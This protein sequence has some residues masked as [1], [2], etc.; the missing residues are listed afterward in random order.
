MRPA[1]AP[2]NLY[3]TEKMATQDV[4]PSLLIVVS[5]RIT[6]G[7][8]YVDVARCFHDQGVADAIID[9]EDHDR[10]CFLVQPPA[11]FAPRDF[12]EGSSLVV[13]LDF[14]ARLEDGQNVTRGQAVSGA[15]I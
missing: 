11:G 4:P 9:L 2:M 8:E 6:N 12:I 15:T 5:A 13:I 7:V 14:A 3:G 1:P 10:T